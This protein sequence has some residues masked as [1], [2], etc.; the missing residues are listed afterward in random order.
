MARR[1]EDWNVGLAKD[2]RNPAFAREFLLAAIDE[3]VDLQLALGKVIRAMGVKEFAAR[4]RM[5]S[6][7]VLRAI[8]PRH[9][10]TQDTINRLLKPFKLRWSLAPLRGR[11]DPT[12]RKQTH[13]SAEAGTRVPGRSFRGE[14]PMCC[15]YARA[16]NKYNTKRGI[17]S[18]RRV[19]LRRSAAFV[20]R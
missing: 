10:P 14:P 4:V 12:P 6:P 1:S 7:N 2:L 15:A 18:R 16:S 5:A 20:P 8:N 17:A 19:E 13:A 3:G 11:R 9:S